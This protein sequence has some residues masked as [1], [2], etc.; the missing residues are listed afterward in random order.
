V[1][2]YLCFVFCERHSGSAPRRFSA[3]SETSALLNS[4]G[5]IS[6]T[7]AGIK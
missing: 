4:G 2:W 3:E 6:D 7:T 5:N 1:I